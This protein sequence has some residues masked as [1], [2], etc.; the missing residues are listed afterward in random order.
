MTVLRSA[1]NPASDDARANREAIWPG[2]PSSTL[3]TPGS[4]RGAARA[5]RGRYGRS[6]A[7][8]TSRRRVARYPGDARLFADGGTGAAAF[9]EIPRFPGEPGAI[10]PPGQRSAEPVAAAD[11]GTLRAPLPGTVVAVHA[12][13]GDEVS[14]N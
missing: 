10:V 8:T 6:S 9:A 14:A 2:S 3:S 1:F 4:P 7:P 13:V 11:D 12:A 5:T